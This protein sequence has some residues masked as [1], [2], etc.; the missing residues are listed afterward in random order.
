[1]QGVRGKIGL[2]FNYKAGEKVKVSPIGEVIGLDG[3]TFS[4][5]GNAILADIAKNGLHIPL[6]ENHWDGPAR[7]WF[8]KDSFELRDDGIY[9]NLELTASGDAMVVGKEYRYLSPTYIMADNRNVL[10]LDSVGLVNRP[11]LLNKE[12]NKK[13][14]GMEELENL[15]AENEALKQQLEEIA[16][17]KEQKEEKKE[18]N[19]ADLLQQI[20]DLNKKVEA[21]S[22]ANVETNSKLSLF[23]GR[24]NLEPN[25]QA[26]TLSDG[27]KAVAHSLGI[28]ADEF[29]KAKNGR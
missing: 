16:N 2:E 21:I 24:L 6:D 10:G 11:N 5:D 3:R 4:V 1:M 26:T 9:A 29:L 14:D 8:D 23:A 7:G 25:A 12:L 15:K 19:S 18:D 20:A 17:T 13:G 28:S 27:E 22:A